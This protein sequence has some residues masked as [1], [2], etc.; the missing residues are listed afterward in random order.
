LFDVLMHAATRVTDRNDRIA[1]PLI[2][3][4]RSSRYAPISIFGRA[5]DGMLLIP[6]RQRGQSRFMADSAGQR[7][8]GPAVRRV[9]CAG[10]RYAARI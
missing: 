6:A 3:E 9:K 2:G 7:L 8:S 5:I 1:P 10:V 4:C